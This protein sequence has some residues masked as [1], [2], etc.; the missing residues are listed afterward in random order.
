MTN[1]KTQLRQGKEKSYKK[2]IGTGCHFHKDT[3]G[4]GKYI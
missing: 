4:K 1:D 2:I 3:Q